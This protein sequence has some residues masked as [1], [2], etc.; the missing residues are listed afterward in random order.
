PERVAE[1]IDVMK[2]L[3]ARGHTMIIATHELNFAK[4][5]AD[6]V[7]FIDDGVILEQAAA[8]TFFNEP[9]SERLRA[10]LKRMSI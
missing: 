1:V 6:R 5:T 4:D 8:Q 10:F 3:A 7:I 9:K 2:K